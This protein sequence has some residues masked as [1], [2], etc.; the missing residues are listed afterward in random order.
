VEILELLKLETS[1]PIVEHPYPIIDNDFFYPIIFSETLSLLI[2]TPRKKKKK[3]K[4]KE[5][6]AKKKML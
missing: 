5:E 1:P 4:K 3:K 2:F 6:E